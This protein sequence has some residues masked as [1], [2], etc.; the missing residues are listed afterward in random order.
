MIVTKNFGI[1]F[2]QGFKACKLLIL[3]DVN[4]LQQLVRAVTLNLIITLH[5]PSG[6]KKTT[7]HINVIVG[8]I[9]KRKSVIMLN[10]LIWVNTWTNSSY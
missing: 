3:C 9:L 1:S 10:P 5:I 8:K 4:C 7:L 2:I 6:L